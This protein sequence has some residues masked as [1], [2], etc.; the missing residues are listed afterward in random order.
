M[1]LT[2]DNHHLSEPKNEVEI[3]SGEAY[4]G[5]TEARLLSPEV[6][7]YVRD[8]RA[9]N[10]RRAY[11]S[12]LQH[13]MAWGGTIP[14]S[15]EQVASYIA[16]H[17]NHLAPSTLNRR[18]ASIAVAHGAKGFPSPSSSELVRSVLKGIRRTKGTAQ[19]QA[20]P[21]LRD[22]LFIVLDAIGGGLKDVR[23]RAL[24]LLGFAG[25]FRRSEL[26]GLNIVDLEFVRHGLIVNLRHSKTDQLG[27]GRKIGIPH[28][29]TKHCPVKAVEAW[30]QRSSLSEGA[31]FCPINRHGHMTLQRLSG[32]AVS[33]IIRERIT[34]A[35]INPDGYSGHSFR[36]GFATSAAMAGVASWRIRKQT[37]HASDVM[38][39]RYIRDGELFSDNAAGAL[40]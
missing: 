1:L 28:G 34:K 10:T 27:E 16:A 4:S 15:Q 39:G 18:L 11:A 35:G 36:S 12:D 2:R 22:D 6:L 26:V 33:V 7:G 13:F 3:A 9:T 21:L 24:L 25:G 17:A 31:I 14:A 30:L 8:S 19:A 23:D 5:P 29:R 20:K 32:E 40:L 37:G 38:L